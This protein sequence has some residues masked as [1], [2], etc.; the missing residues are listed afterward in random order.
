VVAVSLH[1]KLGDAVHKEGILFEIFAERSSKLASAIDLAAHLTPIVLTKK[2]EERMILDL[3]PEKTTRSK[4]F[5][6]DR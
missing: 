6:L 4:P 1:S 3:I 5:N 2:P